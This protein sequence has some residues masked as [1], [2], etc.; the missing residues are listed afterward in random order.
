MSESERREV[1]RVWGAR[2]RIERQAGDLFAGLAEDL[3]ATGESGELVALARQASRD[4][5]RHAARCRDLARHFAAPVPA[6][7]VAQPPRLGP[8]GL[9][10]GQ[11]ALFTS[12]AL[13]CV[14]E[15]LSTALLFDLRRRAVDPMVRATV[16]EILRDEVDHARV[17]WRHL[18]AAAR[19][20]SVAWLSPHLPAML[21][22][23]IGA[24]ASSGPPAAAAE[25]RAADSHSAAPATV[26]PL[27]AG[28]GVL[29]RADA[30]GIMRDAA[31][32]VLFPG[33]ERFGIDPREAAA[34][35]FVPGG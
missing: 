19:R 34:G 28:Y 31:V 18:A 25:P 5:G 21:R 14:T 23:A 33:L 2:E 30:V 29:P 17:G 20:S 27:L 9:P 24:A 1:A 26:D 22:A 13:S 7:A 6:L 8:P 16:N 12:V 35:R 11:R 4:E 32:Q 3:E 10:R 15:T